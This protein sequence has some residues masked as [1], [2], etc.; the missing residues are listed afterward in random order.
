MIFNHN[1][2][3]S[4][5]DMGER[6]GLPVPGSPLRHNWLEQEKEGESR[7]DRIWFCQLPPNP[8]VFSF[9]WF[10]WWQNKFPASESLGGKLLSWEKSLFF[11]SRPGFPANPHWKLDSASFYCRTTQEISCQGTFSF[12]ESGYANIVCGKMSCGGKVNYSFW[13]KTADFNIFG[14]ISIAHSPLNSAFEC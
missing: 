8:Y 2:W 11:R 5:G 3:W 1:R 10:N 13:W 12:A 7:K 9:L 4:K 14:V 6:A